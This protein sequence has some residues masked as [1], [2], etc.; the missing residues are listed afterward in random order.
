MES[1][2][3]FLMILR[4]S[5]RTYAKWR[6]FSLPLDGG[7]LGRGWDCGA[8]LCS[9]KG[10]AHSPQPSPAR[11]EGAKSGFCVSPKNFIDPYQY[12]D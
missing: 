8:S 7:G 2:H 4:K 12:G 11:G 3:L 1:S 6:L 9:G 10:C 5:Y